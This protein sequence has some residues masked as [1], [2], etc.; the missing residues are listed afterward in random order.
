[1]PPIINTTSI[2]NLLSE[3][4]QLITYRPSLLPI[5]KTVTG[6]ILLSQMLYWWNK[7]AK[8]GLTEFYKFQAPCTNKKYKKGDSWLEEL[9]FSKKMFVNALKQIGY[10]TT[11]KKL[12]HIK[13]LQQKLKLSTK[14]QQELI[15]YKTAIIYYRTDINNVT[16]YK[17]NMGHFAK[18][19]KVTY[20]GTGSD[21]RA[22][23]EVPKGNLPRNTETTTETTY[24]DLIKIKSNE[25]ALPSVGLGGIVRSKDGSCS[26]KRTGRKSK[27]KNKLPDNP[28]Q[29]S[30]S[31]INTTTQ[32]Y[33]IQLKKIGATNHDE[34]KK[35]YFDTMDNIYDLFYSKSSPPYKDCRDAEHFIDYNWTIDEL[36]EIFKYQL[37]NADKFGMPKI[38]SIGLFIFSK[39]F[40]NTKSWSP[41]LY[42]HQKLN[43]TND[44]VLDEYGTKLYKS[45]KRSKIDCRDIDN[46][47]LNRI[48]LQIHSIDNQYEFYDDSAS[49]SYPIGIVDYFTKTYIKEQLNDSRFI[50]PYIK[51]K[52][53]VEDFVKIAVHRNVIRKRQYY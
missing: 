34:T 11:K 17:L 47:F 26:I 46:V 40:R 3:D 7:T 43:K 51:K 24:K 38:K 44:F 12:S 19:L 36:I 27:K 6:T 35:P 30:N 2:L 18:L 49:I 37:E 42:W 15:G 5:G 14:E 31:V 52:T 33:Y 16:W 25:T 20:D 4:A 1:M 29:K 8:K 32:S 22:L 39:G 10:K 9:G 28:P 13:S 48:G 23:P 53:F 50:L 45:F 21:Q 41:L